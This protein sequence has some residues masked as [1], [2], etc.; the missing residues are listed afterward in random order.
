MYQ[1]SLPDYIETSNDRTVIMLQIETMLGVK[2]VAEIAAVDGV[3][4]FITS[5]SR[6][7]SM[8]RELICRST[9][10]SDRTDIIFIGPN[11]LSL[12]LG[13]PPS[14]PHATNPKVQEVI[15]DILAATLKAG[16]IVRPPPSCIASCTLQV[17][18][19]L[20]RPRSPLLSLLARNLL[21]QR[22]GG[23]QAGRAGFCRHERWSR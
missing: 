8:G 3:G 2:N 11:D 19:M 15:A 6:E 4:T 13:F 10:Y 21:H 23:R 14:I 16:K 12:A 5:M 18:L 1:Q 7:A 9:V 17:G 20:I 22:R